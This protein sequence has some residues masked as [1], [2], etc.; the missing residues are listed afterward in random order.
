VI[1]IANA[2]KS[3]RIN[4]AV[5]M[6]LPVIDYRSWLDDQKNI[7]TRHRTFAMM[8][9]MIK[10]NGTRDNMAVWTIPGTTP[11][12]N[13]NLIRLSVTVMNEWL[14]NLAADTSQKSYLAKVIAAR[15]ASANDACWDTSGRRIDEPATLAATLA[16]VGV[17]SQLYPLHA[18]DPRL[19]A[20]APR[21]EDILKCQLKQVTV[22]DY[23]VS[24]TP[25][26]LVRL[27]TIFPQGVCDWTKPGVGQQP[28]TDSW[29]RFM[30]EA[31]TWTR[32]GHSS[33]GKD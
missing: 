4:E 1:G 29:L 10:T 30:P 33:F 27:N 24:F 7:H 5:N 16:G 3:G 2:Y 14:E 13:P 15:P 20:G 9:R 26:E 19:V 23:T 28:M 21:S 18:A 32:M 25:A 11:N 8:E 17:C 12:S 31:G 6:T 22:T